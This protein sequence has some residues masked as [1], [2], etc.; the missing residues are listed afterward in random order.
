M[1]DARPST[2]GSRTS[3]APVSALVEV[4]TGLVRAAEP[5]AAQG[6]A[7][8]SLDGKILRPLIAYALVPPSLR[9]MLD[10]RF[11]SGALA[12]QMV[13]EA[14]L[15]HDD[16]LDGA[17][18][19]RGKPTLAA[20]SGP[21]PALVLGDLYLT[22]AYRAAVAAESPPFLR[23]LIRAVERTVA[24][25]VAQGR[26]AGRT[27]DLPEYL[28]IVRGK[29]GELFGA[30]AFLGGALLGLGREQERA[31]LGREIGALYQQVD[32]LLDYCPASRSGKPPLQ[33]YRQGKWTWVLGLAGE[34]SLDRDPG[35]VVEMLFALRHDGSSAAR[36]ALAEL[37]LRAGKLYA[38]VAEL[39]PGDEVLSDVLSGCVAAATAGVEA[40]EIALAARRAPERAKPISTSRAS[41]RRPSPE[42]EVVALARSVG[43][44][45]RW[46]SYFGLGARTFRFA[47]RLFPPEDA[48][49]VRGVYAFCRFTD[50]LVDE[51]HDGATE[52]R[53]EKR[54]EAWRALARSAFE[55]RAVGVPLIDVVLGEAGREGVS[56]RYVDALLA[57]VGMDLS[58]TG[59]A[60]WKD[61]EQYTFGVA[62]AVGGWLTQA[63]GIHDE[64][65]LERAHAL[66]HGMQLTNIVRDVGDDLDRGRIYLPR[67][68]LD[69]HGLSPSDLRTLRRVGPPLPRAYRNL[70]EAAIERAERWYDVAWP[71]IRALPAHYRRPVAVAARAYAGIHGIVRRN[72]YDNLTRRASTS[73]LEKVVLGAGGLVRSTGLGAWLSRTRAGRAY[74]EAE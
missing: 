68:L 42:A 51:P 72:G 6:I 3:E 61:L 19:R 48:R 62:G 5:L 10:E 8:P 34:Q 70:V 53:I 9:P 57:G 63:F 67:T 74:E 11:W 18:H 35:Q 59:Y 17:D 30:A 25:E 21:G 56:W 23:E 37:R 52:A 14:S 39:S 40:Q 45:E 32:D 31:R 60:D 71:G 13:H 22:G 55:G 50:D 7:V 66:G 27:M 20:R 46:L 4:R 36:E 65:V 64:G 49:R 69:E 12:V 41:E 44:P 16:I 73:S 2:R 24:G 43:G 15:L 28:E 1:S 33:D 58:V 47:A 54:L 26:A 38:A 29:S